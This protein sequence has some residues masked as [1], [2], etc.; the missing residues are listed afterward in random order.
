MIFFSVHP[1]FTA[2]VPGEGNSRHVY[3]DLEKKSVKTVGYMSDVSLA[4]RPLP[5]Q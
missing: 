5:T 4:K 1:M 2:S 3:D